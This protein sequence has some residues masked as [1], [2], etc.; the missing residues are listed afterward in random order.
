MA[1]Y[2]LGLLAG[3]GFT[4]YII[5][6]NGMLH[7]NKRPLTEIEGVAMILNVSKV[8]ETYMILLLPPTSRTR[9]YLDVR[10]EINYRQYNE[11]ISVES[12]PAFIEGG[13]AMV[14]HDGE[15]WRL[16]NITEKEVA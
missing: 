12:A 7:D 14:V 8:T 2:F 4:F 16:K 9:E 13:A 10:F 11:K 15:K 1:W 3:F 5:Y 6:Q